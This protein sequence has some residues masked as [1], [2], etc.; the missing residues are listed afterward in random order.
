ML[1]LMGSAAFR[2]F[3]YT[4]MRRSGIAAATYGTEVATSYQEGRRSLGIDILRMADESLSVRC[5]DGLPFGVMALAIAEGMRVQTQEPDNAE[6][7][8]DD[9]DQLADRR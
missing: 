7:S 3:L 9:E 6:I 2:R 4:I 5:D 1:E 8:E